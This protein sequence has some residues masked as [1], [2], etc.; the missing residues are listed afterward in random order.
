MYEE[1]NHK[2]RNESGIS[3]PALWTFSLSFYIFIIFSFSLPFS[4]F[5][6]L[7]V[8]IS[9][10]LFLSFSLSIIVIHHSSLSTLLINLPS[11]VVWSPG[12][13]NTRFR[14]SH[15]RLQEHRKLRMTYSFLWWTGLLRVATECDEDIVRQKEMKTEK[16]QW[17][18]ERRKGNERFELER[19]RRQKEN[20]DNLKGRE[21]K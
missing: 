14:S 13:C 6:S 9:L 4:L 12:G 16:E 11:T 17:E 18:R 8:F 10:F 19:K 20:R 2:W 21:I 7:S 15:Q 3:L 1:I 5:T